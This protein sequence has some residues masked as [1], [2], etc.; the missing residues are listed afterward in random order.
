LPGAIANPEKLVM[1]ITEKLT[2]NS[3]ATNVNDV[4]AWLPLGERILERYSSCD[5][6][7]ISELQYHL[8]SALYDKSD[9][10]K[11]KNFIEDAIAKMENSNS[12]DK[13]F[14]AKYYRLFANILNHIEKYDDAQKNIKKQCV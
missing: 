12:K 8:S 3:L 14:P 7:L 1:E 4:S 6:E 5:E 13:T 11:A 2:V 9:Y 10:S